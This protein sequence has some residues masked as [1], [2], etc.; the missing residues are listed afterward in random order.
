M[1][2]YPEYGEIYAEY[3]PLGKKSPYTRII[4]IGKDND[5]NIIDET[6]R[7]SG[8]AKETESLVFVAVEG[9]NIYC[10]RNHGSM[11]E[12]GNQFIVDASSSFILDK[13]R[14]IKIK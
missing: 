5:I 7:I 9:D 12:D 8:S 10:Y 11:S 6:A 1:Y 3:A 13:R 14:R 2:Y 4:I